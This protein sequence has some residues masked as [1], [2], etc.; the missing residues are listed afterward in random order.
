MSRSTTLRTSIAALAI[1]PAFT[2][3]S[4][5]PI[6]QKDVDATPSQNNAAPQTTSTPEAN[7]EDSASEHENSSSNDDSN[8]ESNNNESNND[9]N[10]DHSNSE[11]SN[12]E[13]TG[14]N[15]SGNDSDDAGNDNSNNTSST[16]SSNDDASSNSSNNDDSNDHATTGSSNNSDDSSSTSDSD[17]GTRQRVP[18]P[19]GS[20]ISQLDLVKIYGSPA[21][22]GKHGQIVAVFK[23]TTD[24]PMMLNLRINLYDASGKKIATNTGLNSVYTTG[25]QYLVTS[26]LIELPV[27]AKVHSFKASL[28]DKTDRPRDFSITKVSKPTLGQSTKSRGVQVLRGTATL[29][30]KMNGTVEA[31]AACIMPD[32]KIYHG[33]ESLNDNPVKN[34]SVDYEV[35]MYDAD[36]VDL[37]EGTCYVSA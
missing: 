30:G 25:S 10:N 6:G 32:G 4:M 23:A 15:G 7:H 9:S 36:K 37:S 1:L 35:P 34:G 12:D 29:R 3:C 27:G 8:N 20:G 13:S 26:N 11:S 22:G 2:A 16:D 21:S 31:N 33:S 18:V 28:V 24:R 19:A 17:T 5:L 14:S